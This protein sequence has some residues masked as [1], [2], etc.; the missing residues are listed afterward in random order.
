MNHNNLNLRMNQVTRSFLII[1]VSAIGLA[2]I[3]FW[4]IRQSTKDMEYLH[5]MARFSQELY[6]NTH[7]T[8]ISI[9]HMVLFDDTTTIG[10]VKPSENYRNRRNIMQRRVADTYNELYNQNRGEVTDLFKTLS[11]YPMC[12]VL[13]NT[14][15]NGEP[16]KNCN[17]SMAGIAQGT[18]G[19]FIQSYLKMTDSIF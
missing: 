11:A 1:F 2:I 8:Y 16:F 3:R 10:Y 7:G 5:R 12:Q 6:I 19:S 4:K 18:L 14:N 15:E 17:I 13:A 9:L